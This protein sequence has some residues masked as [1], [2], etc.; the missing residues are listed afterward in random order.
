MEIKKEDVCDVLKEC[1]EINI[2]DVVNIFMNN[3]NIVV[4]ER[5]YKE[6][7]KRK[8]GVLNCK[9]NKVK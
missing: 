7:E 9:M 8:E 3:S 2:K 1:D 6:R 4:M 5:S